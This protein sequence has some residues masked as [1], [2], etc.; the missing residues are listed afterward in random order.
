MAIELKDVS[1]SYPNGYLANEHLNLTINQGEK[2]GIIGQN[3]AG[4]TTAVK[5]MNR[6][7]KP[8]EG[9]VIIDGINTKDK[10][11][12]QIAKY[13]GY[14]FQNPDDQIFNQTVK[15]EVRY[16]LKK[17]RM[18]P[19]LI[20]EKSD[21]ALELTGLIDSKRKNPFDLPLPTRKFL[22][23]AAVIATDPKYIILDEPTAG[24][25]IR[26]IEVLEKLMDTLTA[27]GMGV[28]TITHDMEFVARNFDR[29]VVMAHKNIIMDS[30]A[31]EVFARN[32]IIE[33]ARIKK[34]EIAL[35]A[36]VLGI[37]EEILF[38]DELVDLLP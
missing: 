23:I 33:D 9:D 29:I 21:R 22:T 14:V 28:I 35:I 6:L 19:K 15:D 17:S 3:G 27:E 30:T 25:D 24:L 8:T 18:D 38:V 5:L 32:D 20:K 10:T 1:F 36:E 31:Q 37:R 7:N 26:G 13:V 2:V 11:T 4:K 34:P 16:M 12:A